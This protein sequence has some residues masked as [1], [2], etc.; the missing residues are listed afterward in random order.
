MKQPAISIIITVYKAESYLT[1]CIDSILAQTW[2]DWEL[3]LID[4]GSPDRSGLMCDEIQQSHHE[5]NIKVIHQAN[6]G[7]AY[8]RETGMKHCTGIYS[9]HIDPDD[10]IDPQ[11]LEELYSKAVDTCADMVV[12]DLALE[13]AK[14]TEILVQEPGDNDIFLKKLLAQNG[15]GSLCNKL[16]RR[17]LYT[18]HNLHFPT[19]MICWEDLYICCNL[20]LHQC[21]IAYVHKAL[22]HYDF[23]SNSNSMVR[24]ATIETLNGMISFCRYFDKALHESQKTWL[25][26][27]KGVVMVTA[28][29]HHLCSEDELRRLFPEIKYWYIN[30]YLHKYHLPAQ[31]GVAKVLNGMNL[32]K[33][34]RILKINTLFQKIINKIKSIFQQQRP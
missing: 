14:R 34:Y 27:T 20:L 12:C 17:E 21:K 16:I 33:S 5:K 6:G 29:R 13:Y 28:Y 9:I 30:K 24:K 23:Y 15:H 3:I 25:Y 32:R 1:R 19:E 31:C 26:E 7:V 10:W 11:M 4:D 8:A 2:N 18:K 22:Y